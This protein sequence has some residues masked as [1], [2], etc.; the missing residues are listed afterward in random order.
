[1]TATPEMV[2]DAAVLDVVNRAS[3][4]T[5]FYKTVSD[6]LPVMGRLSCGGPDDD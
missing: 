6:H 3:S 1:M 4:A 2:G 5:G